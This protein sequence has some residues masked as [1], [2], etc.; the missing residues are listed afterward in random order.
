MPARSA[1]A[2]LL[3]SISF[4]A[5]A[6]YSRG[7][8]L[9]GA[10]FG[11]TVIPG[12]FNTNYTYNSE[13]SFRYFGAKNLTLIRLPLRW[14]RLQ[15][16]LRGPLE[17]SNLARL[18]Q[19]IVWAKNHGAKV[20]IEIHNFGRY[21]IN[22]NGRLNEYILDNFYGGAVKVSGADLADFWGR[23]SAEFQSDS[24]VYGYGLMNEPHDMASANWKAISQSALNAIRATGDRKLVLV[25]GDNYS[26]AETWTRIHG[27]ASWIS[28]PADN[29]AYEAHCY[30][31]SDNSG[32]YVRTYDDELRADPNLATRGP[33]RLANFIDWIRNNNVRGYLGEY[34]I[35][36]NDARWNTVL[37]NFLTSLDAAGFD[38]T[39]WAA[40][41]WWGNYPLS[42]QP[43]DNFNTDR[44]QLPTLQAHLAPGSFTTVSAASFSGA[45][46]APDSL[47][48]GFGAHLESSAVELVD[49][50]GA[51][52]EAPLIF[53][54]PTQIN[55]LIP[56]NVTPGHI[57]VTVKNGGSVIASGN[58]EI[59]PV[60]PSLFTANNDGRGIAAAQILRVKSN[61]SQSYEPVA[62][63]D[64]TQSKFTPLPIDFGDVSDRLFV[65][66]Y[67]TGFRA[68]SSASLSIGATAT[69][70]NYAGPQN[71]F[72]GLD[73]ANAELPRSLMGSGEATL[74]FAADGKQANPVTLSFK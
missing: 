40:G 73:Q 42:V 26:G 53:T 47:V 51:V 38:G 43:R 56:H 6:Q 11:E 10:E 28:D 2:L 15:P 33:R 68:A 3:M 30:F 1:L 57:Q 13:S 4:T 39:Y 63:F 24:G 46:S 29:F 44:P 16:T 36:D 5:A 58:L 50:T 23:M 7:V 12:V 8:N 66:L 71:Q 74:I 20:I 9:A 21:K 35:P 48:A 31:D 52:F 19:D 65:L 37:D 14:E 62:I 64:S 22:E 72:A 41:E 61:G 34:G 25:P 49:S 55:Y 18:R 54:A 45:V 17:V 69:P 60:A 67:G 59:D 27:P 32:T 70:L